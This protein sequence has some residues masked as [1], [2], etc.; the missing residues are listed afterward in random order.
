MRNAGEKSF[1]RVYKEIWHGI[2]IR[3]DEINSTT[4]NTQRDLDVPVDDSINRE[5]RR[6][7]E[8]PQF[9]TFD[10]E[11]IK[12]QNAIYQAYMELAIE[13]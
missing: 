13:K 6:V 7:K 10:P 12:K 11:V 1:A 3:K 5:K 2:K 8:N 4:V 9:A